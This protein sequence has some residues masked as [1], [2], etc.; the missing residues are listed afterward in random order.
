M[1]A[2]NPKY[3]LVSKAFKAANITDEFLDS[4]TFTVFTP[5]NAALGAVFEQ[6][7]IDPTSTTTILATGA[8][9]LPSLTGARAPRRSCA[10][11]GPAHATASPL[12][13]A[14]AAGIGAPHTGAKWFR[15]TSG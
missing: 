15:Q 5:S 2:S 7:G 13:W 1:L 8:A 3:D 4:Q 9:L 14:S 6:Y 10:L 11:A 12:G